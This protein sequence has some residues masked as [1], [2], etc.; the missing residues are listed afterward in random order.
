ME[1]TAYAATCSRE[2]TEKFEFPFDM[3]IRSFEKTL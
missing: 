3:D 2:H 1:W